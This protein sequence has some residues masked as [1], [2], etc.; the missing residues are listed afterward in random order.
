MMLV[1]GTRR[2]RQAAAA[3]GL[4]H[5]VLVAGCTV[6]G[7][8]YT[9]P[10]ADV[11]SSWTELET[12]TL[13]TEPPLDPR[14]WKSAFGDPGLDQLIESALAQNLSLRSAALRVLEARQQLAIAIG[15]QFP[16][17]QQLSG[18]AEVQKPSRSTRD[19]NPQLA[20]TYDLYS[21]GFNL[22]WEVDF[23]GRNRL[24]VRSAAAGFD[25]TVADYDGVMITLLAD[26]ARS[27]LQVRTLQE[28]IKVAQFNLK[29]QQESARIAN[30]KLEAGAVSA[31]DAEQAQTLLHNTEA[32]LVE[33][34]S[35][36]QQVKNSLAV[37][38]GRTP[39]ELNGLLTDIRPIPSTPEEIA[40]GVPQ[41]LI[42]R[43]PD[44]RSAERRLAA[45]GAQIGIAIS[46]LYPQFTIG[47][48]I[49][50]NAT[51][52]G[53]GSASD[54]FKSNSVGSSLFGVFQWNIFNYGRLS[55]NVRLQ[56]ATFQQLLVDYRA[57]VLQ[58]QGEVENAIVAYV[59]DRQLLKAYQSAAA[60]AQRAV[61]VSTAQYE[62]GAV[63]FN[64]VL[65]T[66]GALRQQQD[67]VAATQGA[68][69]SSLVQVY[70]SLGGGWQIRQDLPPDALLP[71]STRQ[72][73]LDRTDYW[74]GILK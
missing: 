48:S 37:L 52:V 1:P 44:I 65:S 14:W 63:D 20:N 4:T 61:D 45:Q 50:S 56:D 35:S 24:A 41:E 39:Q 26:V 72:E 67:L 73:M 71:A 62:D 13:T 21:L 38:L 64:T 32:Q 16:Q 30:A 74:N 49:V 68:V 34:E 58:A 66:L 60:A 31:L 2:F 33:E 40:V 27:Y 23:W 25:A 57:T 22:S 29:L 7:P 3:I 54:L 9:E 69:A 6:V 19:I 55:S 18:S 59:K 28:Q 53:A 70:K 10:T 42:R 46:D 5:L 47:G 43:R 15:Y 36:L 11:Q 51:T 12:K 8:K 17:V